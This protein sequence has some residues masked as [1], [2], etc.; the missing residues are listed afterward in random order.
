MSLLSTSSCLSCSDIAVSVFFSIL[1]Y[2]VAQQDKHHYIGIQT[3]SFFQSTFF[4]Q[5]TIALYT[6]FM[7]D[8]VAFLIKLILVQ[9]IF[10]R[11]G[12]SMPLD[13]WFKDVYFKLL[14]VSRMF[15]IS[16]QCY[17]LLVSA[18]AFDRSFRRPLMFLFWYRPHYHHRCEVKTS[19]HTMGEGWKS[20]LTTHFHIYA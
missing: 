16:F 18:V 1:R 2:T 9:C 11:E 17:L 14:V 5:L 13:C 19:R 20:Y 6:F 12:P 4:V 8:V 10:L 3:F 15:S 7:Q